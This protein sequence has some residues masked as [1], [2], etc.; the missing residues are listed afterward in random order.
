[1]A[2]NNAGIIWRSGEGTSSGAV[3]DGDLTTKV[4]SLEGENKAL[5][6]EL[7]SQKD[8]IRQLKEQVIAQHKALEAL[9]Q[10]AKK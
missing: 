6:G 3:A 7:T 2:T 10:G 5:I 1:M 8:E 4:T 9:L